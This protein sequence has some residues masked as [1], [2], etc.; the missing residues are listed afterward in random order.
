VTAGAHALAGQRSRRRRAGPGRAAGRRERGSRGRA[1]AGVE[2]AGGVF[3]RVVASV[4]C[5]QCV[6]RWR[7]AEPES[8]A[9]VLAPGPDVS[10]N[11]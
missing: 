9:S 4:Q 10:N 7:R 6:Q 1:K 11:R 5:W 8:W 3:R 2:V